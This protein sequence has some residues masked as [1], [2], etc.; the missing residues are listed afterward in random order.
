MI[1]DI[2]AL[3]DPA[4]LIDP[5]P[6]L[7]WLREHDPVHWSAE[8]HSWIVTRHAD[9]AAAF[10]D[11]RLSADRVKVLIH[12]ALAGGD[13]APVREYLRITGDMML[14]KDGSEH[15]RL[16]VLGNR[17]FTPSALASWSPR[18]DKV[19]GELLSKIGADGRFD[20]VADLAEP[21]PASVIAEMFSIP[22]S[23]HHLFRTWADDLARFFGGSVGNPAEDAL[24]ANNASV[25]FERYFLKL[26]DLRK[27]QPGDD[28]MSL[29]QAA[30]EA[31]RLSTAEVAAQCQLILVAGHVTTIDQLANGVYAL[32]RHEGNWER[33][34]ASPELVKSA[35]EEMIRFDPS[36]TLV[37]RVATE[38]IAMHGKEIKAGSLVLLALAA[39][40]RDPAVFANPDQFDVARAPNKHLGFGVGPHQCL[41]MNLARMEL[42]ASLRS[43][44]KRY[45]RLTLDPD[46]LPV[47]KVDSLTFRGFARLP[48]KSSA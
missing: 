47:R 23:D 19:I 1:T 6:A 33:L 4:V 7:A 37:M 40:N 42:E 2:P 43:L 18:V 21:M 20:V 38:D 9:V 27:Q 41:G 35:V 3:T 14:M 45:P 34:A 28:L 25:E 36:V 17:G 8:A 46:R 32:L 22:K 12:I 5:Y 29:F 30:E 44:L 11:P 13:P 16:R 10:R 15:H 26:Y 39:A 24:K 48:V 31:G